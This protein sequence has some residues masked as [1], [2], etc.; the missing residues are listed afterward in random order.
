MFLPQPTIPK[1]EAPLL[2][3]TDI[4]LTAIWI[5]HVPPLSPMISLA[6]QPRA[7]RRRFDGRPCRQ[8]ERR[9][10]PGVSPRGFEKV[11]RILGVAIWPDRVEHKDALQ[12]WMVDWLNSIGDMRHAHAEACSTI[13]GKMC[14]WKR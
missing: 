6:Q 1:Y 7:C 2:S 10:Q 4:L 8:H 14:A 11:S 3:P 5:L 12:N 13:L 9:S